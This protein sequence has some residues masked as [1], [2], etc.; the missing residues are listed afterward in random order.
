MTKEQYN[1]RIYSSWSWLAAMVL[2]VLVGLVGC[3]K[4]K[5]ERSDLGIELDSAYMML[6]RGVDMLVSDSGQTKYR[7]VSPVWIVYDRPDRKE[8][9]FPDS[10]RMYSVDSV[11]PAMQLV[12]ADSAIFYV[13]REEWVLIGNVRIHGLKG[14]KLYTQRLHWLQSEKR[15]FSNDTTYFYTDGRELHGDRFEAKDDL[16]S[17]SIYQSRGD[18]RVEE[19]EPSAPTVAGSATTAPPTPNGAPVSTH[20]PANTKRGQL[21]PGH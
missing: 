16:S 11:Q 8:W 13:P 1:I 14:E 2:A 12:T 3:S 20:Q 15:L 17:Y 7:L 5:V 19:R 9:L 10:L 4:P 21:P 18:F 6:T